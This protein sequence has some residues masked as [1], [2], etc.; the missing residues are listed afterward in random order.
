M[1]IVIYNNNFQLSISVNNSKRQDAIQ[2]Q[3]ELIHQ[4][5]SMQL[6]ISWAFISVTHSPLFSTLIT[7]LLSTLPIT[8]IS[9][10]A[11][12]LF[13]IFCP[14][15]NCC[16]TQCSCHYPHFSSQEKSF[17]F[18]KHL[19]TI[20]FRSPFVFRCPSPQNVSAWPHALFYRPFNSRQQASVLIVLDKRSIS[21]RESSLWN[22]RALCILGLIFASVV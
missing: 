5:N 3:N 13:F 21:T 7:Y 2:K 11:W 1:I 14:S 17:R 9:L 19:S 16:F 15:L 20:E 4:L 22:R 6:S 10:T 12:S 18:H 8:L